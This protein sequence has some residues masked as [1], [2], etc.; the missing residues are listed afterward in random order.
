MQLHFR[1]SEEKVIIGKIGKETSEK[2]KMNIHS[3][4]G[5]D[6][7]NFHGIE[8]KVFLVLD[9]RRTYDPSNRLQSLI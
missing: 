2:W 3:A 1:K 8:T 6:A 4:V 5:R 7:G 9:V